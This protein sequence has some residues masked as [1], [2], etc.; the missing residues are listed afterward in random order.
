MEPV[1]DG[2]HR[3]VEV[4]VDE[5]PAIV[6]SATPTIVSEQIFLDA[7]VKARIMRG[8]ESLPGAPDIEAGKPVLERKNFSITRKLQ[9]KDSVLL[10]LSSKKDSSGMEIATIMIMTALVA[11]PDA[12]LSPPLPDRDFDELPEDTITADRLTSEHYEVTPFDSAR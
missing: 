10:R 2:L 6:L 12:G 7:R 5:A 3:V 8:R 9:N 11:A 4:P 1:G